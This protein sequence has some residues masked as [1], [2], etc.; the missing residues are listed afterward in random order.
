MS[1]SISL[2]PSILTYCMET[3]IQNWYKDSLVGIKPNQI[4][5]PYWAKPNRFTWFG[6]T[7]FNN[8]ICFTKFPNQLIIVWFSLRG[9]FNLLSQAKQWCAYTYQY[10]HAFAYTKTCTYR[11]VQKYTY[12]CIY[13][14]VYTCA[15]LYPFTCAHT[16]TPIYIRLNDIYI[17]KSNVILL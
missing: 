10:T 9:P 11:Y 1:R 17:S 15:Y 7:R 3:L 8:S 12:T 4:I 14:Y 5:E 13:R 2:V 6:L 16:H